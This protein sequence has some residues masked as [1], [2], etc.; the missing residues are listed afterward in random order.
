VNSDEITSI[1]EVRARLDSAATLAS[2]GMLDQIDGSEA[3]KGVLGL[4]ERARLHLK[5]IDR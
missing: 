5:A 2:Q 1:K 4:I 3:F